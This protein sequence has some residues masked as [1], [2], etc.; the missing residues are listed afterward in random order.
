LTKDEEQ[1]DNQRSVKQWTE[2]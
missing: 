1:K 2:S